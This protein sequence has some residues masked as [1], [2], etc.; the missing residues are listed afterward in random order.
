MIQTWAEEGA[1]TARTFVW[2]VDFCFAMRYNKLYHLTMEKHMP[3][4]DFAQ[5]LKELLAEKR[6]SASELARMM[7]YKS[8]NSI[9]RILDGEG[10]HG[11]RLAF[12]ARLKEENPLGLTEAEFE[13]LTEALEISRVG[14]QVYRSNA[15]MRELMTVRHARREQVRVVMRDGGDAQRALTGMSAAKQMEIVMIGK[16]FAKALR[17]A[18]PAQGLGFQRFFIAAVQ[19]RK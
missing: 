2:I 12:F 6:V 10:A 16:G 4:T 1:G 11:A 19:R 9:F 8:R 15:A 3:E 7:Q 17:G 14:V 18:L 13:R 5:S